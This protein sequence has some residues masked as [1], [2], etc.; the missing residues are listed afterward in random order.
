MVMLRCGIPLVPQELMA[1]HMQITVPKEKK[2]LFWH[3]RSGTKRPKAGW[4]TQLNENATAE[5][6][7]AALNI[8]LA[9]S[10]HLIDTFASTNEL[11]T[12]L[13]CAE[14]AGKDIVICF[15]NGAMY[16]TEDDG[17]HVC[18]LDRVDMQKRTV[19]FVDPGHNKPK[20]QTA[21]ISK[22]YKAMK[23]HGPDNMGGCWEVKKKT[24]KKQ[25]S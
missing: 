2:E 5:P 1:H 14:G 19:R 22:L 25:A 18:L 23:A 9:M 4:G 3:I 6:M 11:L 15:Q 10:W 16:G 21:S 20:W 17:G 13:A 24:G 8:P 7:F 12:Y